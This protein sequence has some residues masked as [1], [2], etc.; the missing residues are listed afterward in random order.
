MN[1]DRRDFGLSES[2]GARNIRMPTGER[3]TVGNHDFY[4]GPIPQDAGGGDVNRTSVEVSWLFATRLPTFHA[5]SPSSLR[6]S[7]MYVAS[8][9]NG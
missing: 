3:S 1:V 9:P 7:S 2:H 5:V 4:D 6:G 8:T